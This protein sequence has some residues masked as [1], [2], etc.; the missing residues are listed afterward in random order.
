[1]RA[2][3]TF[4]PTQA[5]PLSPIVLVCCVDDNALQGQLPSE[6]Q[7][8]SSLQVLSLFSNQ[9]TG[10]IPGELANLRLLHTLDLENNDL[11]GNIP[12]SLFTLPL[13]RTMSFSFNTHLGGTLPTSTIGQ[14][15]SL[16]RL[17]LNGCGLTGTLPDEIGN[18]INTLNL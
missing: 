8:M 5:Y 1:M 3:C 13:L 16:E 17:R 12:Q 18:I 2:G 4:G 11:T 6:L 14:A 9:L 7:V 15:R 10:T